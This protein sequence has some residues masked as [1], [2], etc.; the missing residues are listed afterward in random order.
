MDTVL[1]IA[2]PGAVFIIMVSIGFGV[3]GRDLRQALRTPKAFLTG[4]TAQL[5]LV[6][7]FGHL[8]F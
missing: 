3:T 6:P 5:M 2:I 1:D 4:V 7:V 8:D